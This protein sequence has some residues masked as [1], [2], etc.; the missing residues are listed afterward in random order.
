MKIIA[1]ILFIIGLLVELYSVHLFLENMLVQAFINH[2]I[3][4]AIFACAAQ[5]YLR[6]FF[7]NIDWRF[8]L[9]IF[10]LVCFV[11]V[12]GILI[13]LFMIFNIY[14]LRT[15]FHKDVE[16][17]DNTINLSHLKPVKSQYGAGGAI[18]RL[19]LNKYNPVERTNA[20]FALGQEKFNDINKFMY[21]LLVD[22]TD[23]IRLLAF[24]TLEQQETL[25]TDNIKKILQ[26]LKNHNFNTHAEGYA[27][28]EKKLAML[29]WELVYN[30]L[31]SQELEA[32]ILQKALSYTLSA[33]KIL[34]EDA[35]LWT[36]LG[37]I[38]TR[39]QK[40]SQ[41]ESAFAK[42]LSFNVSPSQVL[43]YLAEI[44]YKK[45]DYAATK[46]YL[47]LS[48]LLDVPLIAPVKR[49]WDIT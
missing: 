16:I 36:L 35:I 18:R 21:R 25:I 5:I 41:A 32:S 12:G 49:F 33:L 40:Y 45:G 3:V 47:N 34:S 23:E 14:R 9:L 42:A 29:Y 39:M 1:L 22:D 20:L 31:V 46:Q 24:N 15:K 11:P 4:S 44:K 6:P 10:L 8:Y 17:L 19:L 38:Y 30:N 2:L 26:I 28:Y 48:T 27:K 7:K 13:S 43:P 37:K